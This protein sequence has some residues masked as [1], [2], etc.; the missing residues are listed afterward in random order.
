[1]SAPHWP[2]DGQD[3]P[4]RETSRFIKAGGVNWHVQVSGLAAPAP[5][6]LLLHGTAASTHSWRDL[7]PLLG[8]HFTVI[9]PDLPGH[10][11]SSRLA[12]P[13]PAD[14]GAAVAALTDALGLAPALTIGHSAGAALAL[15]MAEKRLAPP[16]AIISLGGALLPFPGMAGKLFPAMARMLFVNPFMPELFAMRARTPGEVGR[17][18]ARSTGSQIDARGIELYERL[19]RSSGH[20]GGALA[21]MANWNLE[22]L[23]AALP[24]LDLP[25]LLAH[26]ENDTTIPPS[27][28]TKVAGRLPNARPLIL[29]GLGHLAHE[30]APEAHAKLILDFARET[31]ILP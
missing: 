4:A 31:G 11:F 3:W 28:A 8:R 10:G 19:M 7:A 12:R 27:V 9:A 17:F 21:L 26:G 15:T 24:G 23:E 16:R 25:V 2:T 30:E 20:V 14:V 5:V 18:L 22:P 1:M 13:S 29:P 6:C